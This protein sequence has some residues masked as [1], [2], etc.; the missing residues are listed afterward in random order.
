MDGV[1]LHQRCEGPWYDQA[2]QGAP[3]R[4]PPDLVDF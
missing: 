1:L 3:N 4:G 2:A